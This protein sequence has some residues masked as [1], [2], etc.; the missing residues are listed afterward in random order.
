[1]T[2][3]PKASDAQNALSEASVRFD[4][5]IGT[6]SGSFFIC[7]CFETRRVQTN[8]AEWTF[9]AWVHRPLGVM[10]LNFQQ[11]VKSSQ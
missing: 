1:M 9:P 10:S 6:N 8:P 7:V 3:D 2:L 5:W 11:I 4:H